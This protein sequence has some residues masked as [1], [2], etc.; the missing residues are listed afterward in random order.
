MTT[1]DSTRYERGL[2]KLAEV[3]GQTG[4]QVVNSLGDLGRYIV[5]F[6]F[7]DIYSRPGLSL[8]EREIATVA[9]LTAL[10][11]R[12]PQ[13]RVHLEAALHVGITLQEL[14]EIATCEIALPNDPGFEQP[15][16]ASLD[17]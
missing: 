10:G 5:E 7:G 1:T 14:E 9:I 4:Q 17:G 8:R 13:L 3:D 11:G 6:A 2:A 16:L 12:E 15:S